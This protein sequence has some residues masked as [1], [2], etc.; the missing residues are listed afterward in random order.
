MMCGVFFT[1]FFQIVNCCGFEFL[2]PPNVPHFVIG[3]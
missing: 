2:P 1:L 3:Y